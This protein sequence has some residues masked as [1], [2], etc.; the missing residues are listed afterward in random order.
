MYVGPNNNDRKERKY[1]SQKQTQTA[2]ANNVIT[3]PLI[4]KC[5]LALITLK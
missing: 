2:N 1:F 3:S 5:G 4:Q